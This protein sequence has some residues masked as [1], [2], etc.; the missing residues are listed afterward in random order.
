MLTDVMA[1]PVAHLQWE[2]KLGSFRGSRRGP[3][4]IC[5][6]GIHGN[7]PAG[8]IA[9]KRVFEKLED[10]PKDFRGELVGFAGNVA[11]L[12]QGSR[13]IERD[14]NRMWAPDRMKTLHL[15]NRQ[16][17]NCWEECEQKELLTVIEDALRRKTGPA[18]FLD[19]HTTSAPGV[20]FALVS[21]TLANRHLA[22]RLEVPLILGLEENIEGTI[23]NYINQ[24]GY[25]AYGFEAGQHEA[26]E[27]VDYHEAALWITLEAV[28]CLSRSHIPDFEH[29]QTLLR[30]AAPGLPQVMELRY[31]HAINP[32]DEFAMKPGFTN[33]TP[34]RQGQTVAIDRFGEVKAPEA[35]RIFM[36]LYQK[37]GEDGFF[38]VS[39]VKPV[40]L[41]VS[42]LARRLHL[43]KLLPLLPGVSR[44]PDFE[45]TLHVDTRIA[46]WY[47]VEICHL[48]GF[49]KQSTEFG[50]LTISRRKQH[51]KE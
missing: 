17:L 45:N 1:E 41:K 49:R 14:L 29:Y 15:E 44:H 13:F 19:L 46:K 4:V 39:E 42:A 9:L 36:P 31:R 51:V 28:G 40:W 10:R 34:V 50:V 33:F 37:Q 26:P 11:A 5:I 48:L 25:V 8:T 12:S 22:R 6:G 24:L 47:V 27:S 3:M 23:L 35:G 2:R 43:D 38:L 18:I 7:E 16:P 21:D 30:N 20:P 32:T